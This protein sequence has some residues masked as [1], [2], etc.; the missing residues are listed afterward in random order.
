MEEGRG[1]W[2]EGTTGYRVQGTGKIEARGERVESE[3]GCHY[4]DYV[5]IGLT[6]FKSGANYDSRII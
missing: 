3:P 5:L 6:R 1:T 2:N 4:S